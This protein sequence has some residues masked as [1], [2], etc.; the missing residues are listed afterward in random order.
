MD[1]GYLEGGTSSR[2][3]DSIA[4]RA[5]RVLPVVAPEIGVTGVAWAQMLLKLRDT[6]EKNMLRL[7]EAG[8]SSSESEESKEEDDESQDERNIEAVMSSRLGPPKR[9]NDDLYRHGITGTIHHGSTVEGKVACG[10]PIS[11]VMFKLTEEIHALGSRCKVCE[12]YP[13]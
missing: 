1:G 10:R 6:R 11:G 4:G 13:R 5:C 2:K 12:G 3:T 7:V 8:N 9:S